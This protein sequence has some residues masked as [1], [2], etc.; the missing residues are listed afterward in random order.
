MLKRLNKQGKLYF[1][2]G[3]NR[4]NVAAKCINSYKSI[5]YGIH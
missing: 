4:K 5:P 2:Q 1:I 3:K